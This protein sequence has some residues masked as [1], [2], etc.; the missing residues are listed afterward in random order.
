MTRQISSD[1][2]DDDRRDESRQ[3]VEFELEGK[4]PSGVETVGTKPEVQ[5]YVACSSNENGNE[6]NVEQIRT[7]TW[8]CFSRNS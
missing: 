7:L 3:D 6:G 2:A 8:L 1:M 5:F 4:R